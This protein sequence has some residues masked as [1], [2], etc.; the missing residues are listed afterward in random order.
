MGTGLPHERC[1]TDPRVSEGRLP[2]PY[3]N[4]WPHLRQPFLNFFF[5][6]WRHVPHPGMLLSRKLAFKED[7]EAL[8]P[9]GGA[10]EKG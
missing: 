6:C 10:A 7:Y 4:S 5:V 2:Q 1:L 3:L 8:I 9:S